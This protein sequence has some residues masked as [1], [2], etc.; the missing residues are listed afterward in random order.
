MIFWVMP[1]MVVNGSLWGQAD[2]LYT[3]FLL[4]CALFLLRDHSIAAI[5]AF[6]IA[7]SI[8]AQAIFILPFL[9]ILVLKK[10]IPWQSFLLIPPVYFIMMLPAVLAGR[11]ISSL[12]L[13]Y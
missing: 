7:F 1:T 12:A 10:R 6:A 9:A 13:T 3:C 8:K 11:S 2:A 5:T 4:V